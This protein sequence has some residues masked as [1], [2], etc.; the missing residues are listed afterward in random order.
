[1]DVMING[2][3]TVCVA[4]EAYDDEDHK[5][6]IPPYRRHGLYEGSEA[7]NNR[8]GAPSRGRCTPVVTVLRM[9]NPSPGVFFQRR[10][11][12]YYNR[13]NLSFRDDPWTLCHRRRHNLMYVL[14]APRFFEN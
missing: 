14:I 6:D 10:T 4:S 8:C 2:R 9:R 11:V 7:W 5:D 1:M 3:T 13:Q 12:L